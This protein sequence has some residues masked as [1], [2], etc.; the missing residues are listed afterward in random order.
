MLIDDPGSCTT[1]IPTQLQTLQVSKP[2]GIWT[3]W[4]LDLLLIVFAKLNQNAV[5]WDHNTWNFSSQDSRVWEHL[6]RWVHRQ[7]HAVFLHLL[8]HDCGWPGTNIISLPMVLAL[9]WWGPVQIKTSPPSHLQVPQGYIRGENIHGAPYDFRRAANEHGQ[10]PHHPMLLNC[11]KNFEW[12][13]EVTLLTHYDVAGEY[14]TQVKGLI[15]ETFERNNETQV[16][17]VCHRWN[18]NTHKIQTF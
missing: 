6:E 4:Y 11:L 18:T 2:G 12:I 10:W 1:K 14:F 15:E 17:L 9:A 16:V 3:P 7:E 8:R 13:C 5:C